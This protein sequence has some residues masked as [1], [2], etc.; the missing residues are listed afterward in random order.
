MSTVLY[1][2]IYVNPE[3]GVYLTPKDPFLQKNELVVK[4]KV[5]PYRTLTSDK[6]C[7]IAGNLALILFTY[8]AFYYAQE[9][10]L[11]PGKSHI[12]KSIKRYIKNKFEKKCVICQKP[13]GKITI[14]HTQA[15]CQGGPNSENNLLPLCEKHHIRLHEFAINLTKFFTKL[16]KQFDFEKIYRDF[17]KIITFCSQ[18]FFLEK[19]PY[20]AYIQENEQYLIN[21]Q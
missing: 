4:D 1:N 2:G 5:F 12:S 13:A 15:V 6:N 3:Y 10:R 14:H 8:D 18:V 20:R 9:I 11:L 21:I 17:I 7:N 16:I 19:I